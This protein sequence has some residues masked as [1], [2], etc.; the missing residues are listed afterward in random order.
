MSADFLLIA[1]WF[2]LAL[3]VSALAGL[4]AERRGR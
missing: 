3:A 1:A 2:L 4:V